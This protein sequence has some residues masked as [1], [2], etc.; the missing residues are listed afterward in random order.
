M[1][2]RCYT[3]SASPC[4]SPVWLRVSTPESTSN[5]LLVS[6]RPRPGLRGKGGIA[7]SPT[8]TLQ[9]WQRFFHIPLLVIVSQHWIQ[10]SHSSALIT[11]P[12]PTTLLPLMHTDRRPLN[13][14][15]PVQ[16]LRQH[17]DSPVG[18]IIVDLCRRLDD[19]I[20]PFRMEFAP[21]VLRCEEF[22]PR[23]D[24]CAFESGP[25]IWRHVIFSERFQDFVLTWVACVH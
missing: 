23:I 24:G 21:V 4:Y 5:L 20:L 25:E 22:F 19:S 12:L 18:M 16:D 1:L 13:V 10:P 6:T 9:I 7:D 11:N 15:R 8:S 2:L 3:L 17:V 14:S